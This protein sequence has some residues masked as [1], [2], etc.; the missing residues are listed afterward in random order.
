[1][2]SFLNISLFSSLSLSNFSTSSYPLQKAHNLTKRN[3]IV[4]FQEEARRQ[5]GKKEAEGE[6]MSFGAYLHHTF[7]TLISG[8]ITCI[9]SQ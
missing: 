4:G 9:E 7:K 2:V 3:T 5:L 1:M 6:F 8:L